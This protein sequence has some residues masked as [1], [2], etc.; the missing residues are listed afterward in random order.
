M[1]RLQLWLQQHK[2]HHEEENERHGAGSGS[3]DG[4]RG[5][6]ERSVDIFVYGNKPSSPVFCTQTH[7]TRASWLTF[8][9][10]LH[11][12]PVRRAR[13]G[14]GCFWSNSAETN[15]FYGKENGHFP[16]LFLKLKF[17]SPWTAE[18]HLTP[19]FT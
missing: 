7:G 18:D 6:P 5:D 8:K 4:Q 19:K 11:G 14:Q 12:A 1:E 2:Q 15:G 10:P 17:P 13:Y 3:H 16:I 9:G